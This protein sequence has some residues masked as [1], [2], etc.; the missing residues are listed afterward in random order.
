[1]T[2]V[3]RAADRH[4]SNKR[5]SISSP[6]SVPSSAASYRKIVL[7]IQPIARLPIRNLGLKTLHN[8]ERFPGICPLFLALEDEAIAHTNHVGLV[9][10]R[11]LVAPLP[12][13]NVP[14]S[15][16]KGSSFP[17]T[18]ALGQ[19]RLRYRQ[20]RSYPASDHAARASRACR[21]QSCR[22]RSC[23]A[24]LH[25]PHDLAS[26]PLPLRQAAASASWAGVCSGVRACASPERCDQI[27]SAARDR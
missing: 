15:M 11:R 22:N 25:R 19:F 3:L 18:G 1:M 16:R 24:R 21:S 27:R 14:G 8:L 7:T 12:I 4:R 20:Q 6:S 23:M 26:D 5:R 13:V 10:G 9:D 17:L 2:K